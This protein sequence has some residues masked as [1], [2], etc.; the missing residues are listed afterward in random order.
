MTFSSKGRG[1]SRA[2]PDQ[3]DQGHD[4][5][6]QDPGTRERPETKLP[7]SCLTEFALIPRLGALVWLLSSGARL[8]DE[9]TNGHSAA[10]RFAAY[11]GA[12]SALSRCS[13]KPKA[14]TAAGLP[15]RVELGRTTETAAWATK[16]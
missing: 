14:V 5:C 13:S 6:G 11:A 3:R 16:G 8:R 1:V 4:E 15:L 10:R 12:A 2:R 7:G 9:M